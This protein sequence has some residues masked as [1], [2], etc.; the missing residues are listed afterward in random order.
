MTLGSELVASLTEEE[1]LIEGLA[2]LTGGVY[3]ADV[4]GEISRQTTPDAFDTNGEILPCALVRVGSET[5]IPP[6]RRGS[7]ASVNVY[8]YQ[9]AGYDVILGAR[10]ALLDAWHD[11]QI[12]TGTWALEHAQD[13]TQRDPALNCS[14]IVSTY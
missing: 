10:D 7:R 3:D 8:F 11:T 2:G 14:L 9:Y 6:Y 4:V 1:E 12:G 13:I 5:T